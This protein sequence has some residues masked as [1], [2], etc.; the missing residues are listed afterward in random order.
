MESQ[1]TVYQSLQN[2]KTLGPLH[3]AA[4]VPRVTVDADALV[5]T[6]AEL[7]AAVRDQRS[8]FELM[9]KESAR[10]KTEVDVRL[11]NFQQDIESKVS[12][13]AKKRFQEDEKLRAEI[14]ALRDE[15][16]DS[17]QSLRSDLGSLE[18]NVSSSVEL[19]VAQL[20]LA[21]ANLQQK[22]SETDG[23]V[24]TLGGDVA[25]THQHVETV[26]SRLDVDV[27]RM[28]ATVAQWFSAWHLQP[29]DVHNSLQEGRETELLLST[30]PFSTI[31]NRISLADEKLT[32]LRR[33]VGAA[34]ATVH[35]SVKRLTALDTEVMRLRDLPA[36]LVEVDQSLRK[37]LEQELNRIRERLEA[38][39]NAPK[40]IPRA[41]VSDVSSADPHLADA[42]RELQSKVSSID[43]CLTTKADTRALSSYALV[44]TTDEITNFM[45]QLR[46][47]L[48][49]LRNEPR[50]AQNQSHAPPLPR[51]DGTTAAALLSLKDA[52]EALAKR[53]SAVE[54]DVELLKNSCASK[55][56]VEQASHE[57]L[58]ATEKAI[59]HI[60]DEL[61]RMIKGV[62]PP[63]P[64]TDATSGR[65][66]CLS[67]NRDAGPLS[68]EL[69]ERLSRTQFPPSSTMLSR[70]SPPRVAGRAV[71]PGAKDGGVTSSRRKLQN[72]YDWLQSKE[73]EKAVA[74]QGRSK[75]PPK[76]VWL[77]SQSGGGGPGRQSGNHGSEDPES[78][79]ADGKYYLGIQSRPQSAG[80]IRP[81]SAMRLSDTDE[82]V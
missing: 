82:A 46:I 20:K 8:L 69:R 6:V 27:E 3:V 33:D 67:C 77:G 75:T 50:G 42:I 19:T 4:I 81:K 28:K 44:I 70:D 47:D 45:Q 38:L 23:R 22:V 57:T 76:T 21:V 65:F 39:E 56:D 59:N 52:A 35:D 61:K 63:G 24:T 18:G 58:S 30:P 17:L 10:R 71:M 32:N 14:K 49:A 60:Y 7:W 66:R 13:E 73:E 72:Y 26:A 12:Q 9:E 53:L 48:D 55:S 31:G 1:L 74:A 79:G 43:E 29:A 68:E 37:L 34:V 40:T 15:F 25:R 54:R 16:T 62:H 5:A 78:I 41:P 80:S 11:S 64:K 36:R 51:G 2:L